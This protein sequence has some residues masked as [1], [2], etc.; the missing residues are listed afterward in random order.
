M[1]ISLKSREE[2]GYMREA[3]RILSACHR[4]IAQMIAP[5]ITSLTIDA[6]VEEYLSRYGA[7]PEQKGYR[8]FPFAICSSVNDTVCHG[9]PND[10]PLSEGDVITIDIVVNKDGWLA[11]SGWSYGV[12]RLSRPLQKLLLKTEQALY[13]GIDQARIGNTIGDIGYVI[14]KAARKGRF[15]VVK[16]LVGHGIGKQLHEPPDVPNYG[17]RGD[18]ETLVEGMVITVEPIFT[19]GS[20]GAVLWNDDGWSIQTADGT[21]GAQFEHTVAVTR[22]GPMILTN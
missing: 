17:R 1:E 20:T 4:E 10:V 13:A 3:G 2:I 9:F 22:E 18:G 12:G 14:D 6:F 15:G 5:G 7:S 16:P 11:D 19:L 8:G 21:S